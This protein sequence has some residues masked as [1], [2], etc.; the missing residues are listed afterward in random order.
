MN[1]LFSSALAQSSLSLSFVSNAIT[2]AVYDKQA[3]ETPPN[4]PHIPETTTLYSPWLLNL[5]D[6]VIYFNQ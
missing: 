5:A 2:L 3:P 1:E 4:E 6:P